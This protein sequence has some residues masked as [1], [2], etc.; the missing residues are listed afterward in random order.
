MPANWNE[1]ALV[2]GSE[3]DRAVGGAAPLIDRLARFGFA[4]KGIVTI[5]IGALALRYALGWG[6]GV[7][8][9]GGALEALFRERLGGLIL[10]ML[11]VGLAAYAL[12]MFVQALVDPE[13]KGTS[14]QGLAERIA[15]LVTGIGYSLLSRAAFYLLFARSATDGMAL[16]DLAAA[17]LTPYIG[18]WIVG[19]A[20]AAVMIAGVLQL[21]LGVTAGF[22]PTFRPP[23]SIVW[24]T[25]IFSTG[26]LGYITLGVLSLMVGYSLVQAAVEYAPSEAGGWDEALWLI[27]GLVEGRW[28][29][30]IT[31]I[32]LICYGFYFV[33]LMRFRRL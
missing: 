8:G 6:G 25:A 19:L 14:L 33:L 32:G 23:T 18:R 10:G 15:F 9:P 7:T 31:A 24:M 2:T 29:L 3:L 21:R 17:V 16:E 27:V 20:G 12:W 13:R 11:A 22:R 30:G 5:L 28:L 1:Q 26:I 4:I